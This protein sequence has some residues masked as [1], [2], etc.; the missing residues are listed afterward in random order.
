MP[1]G[2]DKGTLPSGTIGPI[3]SDEPYHMNLRMTMKPRPSH[4]LHSFGL[5]ATLA[6]FSLAGCGAASGSPRAAVRD[7]AGITIVENFGTAV[8][9]ESGWR[10]DPEPVL[11]I[12]TLE[13]EW[14]SQLFGVREALRLSD[15]RIAI[16]NAGTEEIRIFGPDG[17]FQQLWGGDGEGPGEFQGLSLVGTLPGDTLVAVGRRTQRIS[18][19]HPDEG[20]IYSHTPEGLPGGPFE[21]FGLFDDG[22]IVLRAGFHFDI[23]ALRNG[24]MRGEQTYYSANLD[25]SGAVEYPVLPG[26]EMF[27]Q[28]GDGSVS[29]MQ[30]PFGKRPAVAV[31][32]ER[33]YLGGGDSYE[34]RSYSSEGVL[35]RI[36]R[37]D[38]EPVLLTREDRDR[39]IEEQVAEA[40][41]MD[42]AREI[43][44]SY[45][46]DFFPEQLAAY[47]SFR[48]DPLDC[49]W[50]EETRLPGEHVPVWSVFD[51][52]GRLQG[53]VSLPP[54]LRLLEVGEDYILG[55]YQDELDVEYVRMYRLERPRL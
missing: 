50:V 17:A 9:D 54:D 6:V 25:G 36:L 31:S 55:L 35:D 32:S 33:V 12:G 45:T 30:L 15:G 42:E 37:L 3:S 41:D 46:D 16:A 23:G 13:G 49:L 1:A 26:P 43:R 39:H 2:L 11:S 47:L 34:I 52:E 40:R 10:V 27:V 8:P 21:G 38:Q 51:A 18:L 4:R 28:M 29:L 7:S 53:R 48:T 20:H 19:V 5:L 24:P 22:R 44:S 14:Q